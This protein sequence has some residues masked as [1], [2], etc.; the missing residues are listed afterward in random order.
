MMPGDKLLDGSVLRSTK[1]AGRQ[2]HCIYT[3]PTVRSEH[4]SKTLLAHISHRLSPLAHLSIQ[5]N[6]LEPLYLLYIITRY[7][8]LKFYAEPQPFGGGW[9]GS[10]VLQCRQQPS[11]MKVHVSCTDVECQVW[12]TLT[13][14]PVVTLTHARVR[15][16]PR[17]DHGVCQTFWC[18]TPRVSP[19][20]HVTRG[21]YIGCAEQYYPLWTAGSC[22]AQRDRA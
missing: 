19:C 2:D 17:G 5:I 8:G 14:L 12:S 11:N 9:F 10:I 13:I 3:S 21:V 22:M 1:C 6:S 15:A 7:A 18:T 20:A 16:G 4:R